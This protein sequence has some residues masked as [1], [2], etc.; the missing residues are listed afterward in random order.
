MNNDFITLRCPN[1][2]GNLSVST[3]STYLS[4]QNC[5]TNHILRNADGRFFLE[6]YASCPICKRNDRSIKVSALYKMGQNT[7]L[8]QLLAPPVQPYP[9]PLKKVSLLF[10]YL[11][12]S[13]P[14]IGIAEFLAWSSGNSSISDF[15]ISLGLFLCGAIFIV[16]HI[17]KTKKNKKVAKLQL[18]TYEKSEL[19]RWQKAIERWN[20]LYYC[21]RDDCIF[22]PSENFPVNV[23]NMMGYIY[24]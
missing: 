21:E 18:S 20:L 17:Q 7:Q 24:K 12:I 8:I 10:F 6:S 3:K 2:G 22:I 15:L 5:G 1:C 14:I 4:C 9:R 23:H 19:P 11:G 13:F 16:I